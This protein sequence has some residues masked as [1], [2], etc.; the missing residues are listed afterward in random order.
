[1]ATTTS[2][3]EDLTRCERR[4][5]YER[6]LSIVDHNSGGKQ[7]PMAVLTSVRTIAGYVGIDAEDVE[8]RLQRGVKNGDL[9]VVEG[10][11]CQADEASVRAAIR[12]EGERED[13]RKDRLAKLNQALDGVTDG[14]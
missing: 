6:V 13:T 4:E 10:R 11:V 9:V 5:Q 1:M 8:K 12:Y 2:T 7:R 14:E 3:D